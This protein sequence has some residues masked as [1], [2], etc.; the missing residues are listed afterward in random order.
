MNNYNELLEKG[1][2]KIYVWNGRGYNLDVI[3]TNKKQLSIDELAYIC[4]KTGKG[5]FVT[6]SKIEELDNDDR[7][8]YCD[9]SRY[10][11]QNGFLLIENLKSDKVEIF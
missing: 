3:S 11:F 9:M 5:D 7:Y 10:G 2:N 6:D 8:A 1:K 4:I